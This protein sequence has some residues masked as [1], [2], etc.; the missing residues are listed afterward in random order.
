MVVRRLPFSLYSRNEAGEEV[1]TEEHFSN[2]LGR[3]SPPPPPPKAKALKEYVVEGN[4]S[5]FPEYIHRLA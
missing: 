1:H 5:K 2:K 4:S 3:D